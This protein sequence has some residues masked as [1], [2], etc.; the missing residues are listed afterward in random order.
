MI[1]PRIDL[2]QRSRPAGHRCASVPCDVTPGRPQSSPVGNRI[3]EI[4]TTLNSPAAS[5]GETTLTA[6]ISW[7]AWHTVS[8]RTGLPFHSNSL[9]SSPLHKSNRCRMCVRSVCFSGLSSAARHKTQPTEIRAM[10][11]VIQ[12]PHQFGLMVRSKVISLPAMRQKLG[13]LPILRLHADGNGSSCQ[14][15]F[16]KV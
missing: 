7:V 2:S 1:L 11:V 8:T 12:P 14:P 6:T 4:H 16:D 15:Q 3:R 13:P 5:Q 9:T 10:W